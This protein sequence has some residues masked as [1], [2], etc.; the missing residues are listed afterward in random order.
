MPKH[1]IN[2]VL[3]FDFGMK[4]IGVAVGQT[5]TSTSSALIILSAQDGVPRW[6]DIQALIDEWSPDAFIVGL[7]LDTN[8]SFQ[9]ITYA[10]QKFGRKIQSRFKRPI[11]FVD[12]RYTSQVARMNDKQLGQV[13]AESARLI[14]QS[15]FADSNTL[16]K[17]S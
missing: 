1:P 5:V 11:Y 17:T 10:A 6:S 3:G 8:G 13:D 16:P 15:W 12:E 14:L 4:K 7:P 9:S 2:V